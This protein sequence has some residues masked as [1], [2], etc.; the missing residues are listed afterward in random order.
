MEGIKLIGL[1]NGF[2]QDD[3]LKE[4]KKNVRSLPGLCLMMINCP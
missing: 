4:N 1:G 3:T 2:D